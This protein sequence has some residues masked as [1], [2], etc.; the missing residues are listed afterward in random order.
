MNSVFIPLFSIYQTCQTEVKLFQC[1]AF[2]LATYMKNQEQSIAWTDTKRVHYLSWL[3]QTI[4][5]FFLALLNLT[6]PHMLPICHRIPS[7]LLLWIHFYLPG[8][9]SEPQR[10]WNDK[11]LLIQTVN[12]SWPYNYM[13]SNLGLSH[14]FILHYQRGTKKWGKRGWEKGWSGYIYK[15]LG[16]LISLCGPKQERGE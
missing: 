15:P 6:L 7:L 4:N 1:F 2:S 16:L 10:L 13:K 12:I 11:A 5:F 14:S 8:S 9:L 3:S